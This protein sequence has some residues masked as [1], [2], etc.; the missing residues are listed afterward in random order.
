PLFR[1]SQWAVYCFFVI[2]GF[3]ITRGL[4]AEHE[5]TGAISIAGFFIRRAFRIL[6]PLVLYLMVLKA[7]TMGG[8]IVVP[9]RDLAVAALFACNLH[10]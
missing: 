6:P 1:V 7:L 8:L 4:I 10:D 5:R 3:V 2:S 9:D